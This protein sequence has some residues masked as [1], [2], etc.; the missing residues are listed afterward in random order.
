MAIKINRKQLAEERIR[1]VYKATD[2]LSTVFQRLT[3]Y[4]VIA[5]DFDGNIIAYNEGAHQI[6]GYTPEEIIGKQSIELLFPQGFI[7]SGKLRQIFSKLVAQGTF[8]HEGEKVRKNGEVF[9]AQIQ[10]TLVRGKDNGIVGFVEVVEDLTQRRQAEANLRNII[11]SSVDSIV[12]VDRDG[13]I[14]FVNPAFEAL[15]GHES[16]ELVGSLFGFPV[17]SGTT[18]VEIARRGQG[19]ATA[20]MRMVGI[21]WEGKEGYLASLRDISE[22]KQMEEALRD[23]EE[24][25]RTILEEIEEGY[26]ELNLAGDVTFVNKAACHQLGRSE[27][28]LSGMNYRQYV[29]KEDIKSVYR[30][31][32][33]VYR[34]GEPLQ[35]HPFAIIRKDG[36]QVFLESSVA[37]LR[38][39]Q[40]RIIGFRSVSRDVTERK[41]F[42]QKLAD[43]ATHDSLTGLP[44]RTLLK[45]RLT[46]GL[47]LSQRSG[48]RLAVFMLDL[49]KFKVINDTMGHDVGD[50]LL[51]SVGER[52]SGVTRKSDTV[53]RIGGDEFALVLP[54]VSQPTDAAK[55]AQRVLDIFRKP[56]IFSDHRLNVT[57]SIG[58]AIYPEDGGNIESLLKNADIAMYWAKE[59]GRDIYKFYIGSEAEACDKA[60][61][62]VGEPVC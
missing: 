16:E 24:R 59:Q 53:A 55:L 45:D 39:K 7:R 5:A 30:V 10:F 42:E 17:V 51:K 6:Y 49:D 34:T 40:G 61:T 11:T 26:Y 23:S 19:V 62:S 44:N 20:E 50:Q 12:V 48:N 36:T 43:M 15:A 18:E 8:F 60:Q 27:K 57:T 31:W 13:L 46:M 35:S 33:K 25:Y 38:N 2:F 41:K 4:A 37:L 47:A 14:R 1:E 32:N 28:E 56:F 58:I 21:S 52:L 22:R 3:G 9:P 54:Q 29:A